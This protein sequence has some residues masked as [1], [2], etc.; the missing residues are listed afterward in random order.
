MLILQ[1]SENPLDWNDHRFCH[2]L[3]LDHHEGVL[4]QAAVREVN[5]PSCE[6]VITVQIKQ[7]LSRIRMIDIADF[8]MYPVVSQIR[9]ACPPSR[10]TFIPEPEP[11]HS[12]K[13]MPW[14][15]R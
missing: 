14:C 10:Q 13:D 12:A 3:H 2:P 15:R 11:V 5:D 9:H 1:R 7:D 6:E 8:E 4:V